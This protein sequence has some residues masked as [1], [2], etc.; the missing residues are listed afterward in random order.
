VAPPTA[1]LGQSQ[2]QQFTATVT[3]T[4]NTAVTWSLVPAGAGTITTAGLYTAPASIAASQQVTVK[5][6][7]AA[8]NVTAGTAAVTLNPPVGT[9]TP[10]RVNGG[11]PAY[12]DSL[13]QLWSADNGFSA[14]STFATGSA[15]TGTADPTLYQTE[16]YGKTFQYL[17]TVPSGSYNVKLKYAEIFFTGA[18]QRVFNVTINGAAVETN[19]DIFA[20]AGAPNKAIDQTF[21]VSSTG[22]ITIQFTA[23]VDNAKISAI[24]IV[25]AGGINVSVAPP[26]ASLGQSQTQQFTATV[27]GTTNT[28]VTWSLVPAGA[29][30]IT[31]AG[32]YTAPA[33]IAASQQVT[34]K[35]TSATDNVTAGTAAVTLNPPVGTFTPIRVNGGGP[36]YTDSLGQLWSADNSF[37]AGST[38]STGAAITGTADPTL[39]Q[40]ERFG[41][42][43]YQFTVPSGTYTVNLKFAEIWWTQAGQRVFNVTINGAAVLTNFDII[44]AA[45]SPNQAIDRAFTVSSTGTIT[46]QF[47]AVVDN[48]K[49]SAIEIVH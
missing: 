14:G 40:T 12:T 3:G 31:T 18:G 32:L 43:Q 8:D 29:G 34:V 20:A 16:R 5:A 30:T 33:S 7:S 24:E 28:A 44:A 25:R 47:A 22:T 49:I 27:T 21:T 39:Y 26:T 6:T 23:V 46:I 36:A 13:G 1:S 17:F 15:I 9:F 42:L 45:G 19:F 48:A 2:T 38:F 41:N 10:I 37:S 35:A 4:T 11:G